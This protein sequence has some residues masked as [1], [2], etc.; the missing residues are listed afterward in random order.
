[1]IIATATEALEDHWVCVFNGHLELPNLFAWRCN[2]GRRLV[3]YKKQL[4]WGPC[5][6]RIVFS[7]EELRKA[8]LAK[9]SHLNPVIISIISMENAPFNWQSEVNAFEERWQPHSRSLQLAV[10]PRKVNSPPTRWR[11]RPESEQEKKHNENT[12]KCILN[13]KVLCSVILCST[14]VLCPFWMSFWRNIFGS[15]RG[16]D[17]GERRS[18]GGHNLANSA[19]L[20]KPPAVLE[21][22]SYSSKTEKFTF[23]IQ[24]L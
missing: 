23:K 12:F 13:S 22:I 3:T 9:H 6:M 2:N 15:R 24:F 19:F 17:S 14:N 4:H 11:Q 7:L 16:T 21:R 18:L 20:L 1:M 10:L 5:R 8:E